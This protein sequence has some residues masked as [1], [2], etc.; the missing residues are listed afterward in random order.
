VRASRIYIHI[1]FCRKA[2]IYCNFHFTTQLASI[3][4]FT[5]ALITEIH[6]RKAELE[7]S[8]KSIYFGGGTPSVIHAEHLQHIMS[9][10]HKYSK[11]QQH[12]EITMEVNPEDVNEDRLTAWLQ[13]GINRFSIGIQSLNASELQWMGRAHEMAKIQEVLALFKT[14]KISNYNIDMIFGSGKI[15]LHQWKSE[16]EQWMAIKAPHMAAYQLT[17]EPKTVLHKVQHQG[18]FKSQTDDALAAYFTT[19][20]EVLTQHGYQ[21]YEI[22]NYALP[23]F[24][25]QHNSA[26]WNAEPYIGLGPSAHSFNGLNR[27]INTSGVKAYIQ[28]AQNKTIPFN[29]EHLSINERFNEYILTQL[30]KQ[31]GIEW[32]GLQRAFEPSIYSHV[33][34]ILEKWNPCIEI[35]KTGFHLNLKGMLM[36][37]AICSDLFIV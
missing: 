36:A 35:T 8:Y 24:E 30:R 28:H 18:N 32:N 9:A 6:L 2:C 20:H 16:L 3:S 1:P 14:H 19:T 37:D 25:A 7:S 22:S 26:Y 13:L 10:I 4:A 27:R 12:A 17:I 23:G 15:A 31:K 29:L 33:P 34:K 21:H 5:D 11:A